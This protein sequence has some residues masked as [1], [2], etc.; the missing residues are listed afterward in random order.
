MEFILVQVKNQ[1]SAHAAVLI[2]GQRNGMTGKLIT[3]GSPGWIFISVDL[4]HAEL[5]NVNVKNTTA[6]HPMTIEI[7]CQ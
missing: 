2:N 7:E 5:K 3:L 4:P 6:L 1:P